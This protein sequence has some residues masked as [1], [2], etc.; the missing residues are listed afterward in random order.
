MFRRFQ[1][2]R[3]SLARVVSYSLFVSRVLLQVMDLRLCKS[4]GQSGV[5][6]QL[7]SFPTLAVVDVGAKL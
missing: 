1:D 7:V 6:C 4:T 5:L 3:L 2:V